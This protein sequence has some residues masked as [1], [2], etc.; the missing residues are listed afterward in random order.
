MIKD[1]W[2]NSVGQL[3]TDASGTGLLAKLKITSDDT[4]YTLIIGYWPIPKTSLPTVDEVSMAAYRRLE[5]WLHRA[6]ILK[7]PIKWMLEV[8]STWITVAQESHS[9]AVIT[10]D[11]NASNQLSE[12]GYLP[13]NGRLSHFTDDWNMVSV[14]EVI[15]D[16][17]VHTYWRGQN[18][19]SQ[20]DHFLIDEAHMAKVLD[21]GMDISAHTFT[22][23]AHKP[24]YMTLAGSP[25]IRH[26]SPIEPPL[27]SELSIQRKPDGDYVR[28]EES[29]AMNDAVDKV[30]TNNMDQWEANKTPDLAERFLLQIEQQAAKAVAKKTNDRHHLFRN[31]PHGWS[32]TQVVLYAQLASLVEVRRRLFGLQGRQRWRRSEVPNG[33]RNLTQHWYRMAQK[34]LHNTEARLIQVGMSPDQLQKQPIEFF[35]RSN[36]DEMIHE[37][38]SHLH[39]ARRARLRTELREAI[40]RREEKFQ[41]G[42]IKLFSTVY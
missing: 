31:K 27:P 7:S 11:F 28:T 34:Y 15:M 18:P 21:T 23:S 1:K 39:Y 37:V 30:I 42:K 12:A 14:Q 3:H 16:T 2:S 41:A 17:P 36:M 40:R 5:S 33:L 6:H 22:I 10:G 20:L 4:M 9:I 35:T 24:I 32:P 38:N 25:T 13:T 8:T 29:N 19:I 26:H